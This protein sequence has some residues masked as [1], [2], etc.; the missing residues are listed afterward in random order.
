[1]ILVSAENLE[2]IR[3]LVK[4]AGIQAITFSKEVKFVPHE[5]VN[6]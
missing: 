5:S 4:E 2:R 1:V 3:K 6:Y